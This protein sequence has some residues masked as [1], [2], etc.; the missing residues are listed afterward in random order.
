MEVDYTLGITTTRNEKGCLE[1]MVTT[2]EEDILS[3]PL[4]GKIETIICLNNYDQE[5]ERIAKHVTSKHTILRLRFTNSNPG[6]IQAQKKILKESCSKADFVIFFDSD[7]SIKPGSTFNLIKFMEQ[8][9][10]VHAASGEQEIYPLDSFWYGV[11]NIIG[12]NPQI[13]SPR[14]YLTGKIFAVR[15][16]S[17]FVPDYILTDDAFLSR[18]LVYKYGKDA[19]RS[20]VPGVSVIYIGPKTLKDYFNKIRRLELEMEK[21]YKMFPEFKEIENYFTK[22]R[23]PEKIVELSSIEKLQLFLHDVILKLCKKGSKFSRG[24][25]WTPLKTTKDTIIFKKEK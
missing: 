22:R 23:L 17:Y 14:K 6:L 10:H 25:V 11:Y 24:P 9:P 19:I 7:V 18:Y 3:F 21:I 2:L 20:G 8:N 15:K 12:L 13:M 4:D 1:E 16:R 5:T